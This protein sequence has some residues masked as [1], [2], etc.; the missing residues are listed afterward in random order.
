MLVTGKRM[1]PE[2]LHRAIVRNPRHLKV[3]DCDLMTFDPLG[4]EYFRVDPQLPTILGVRHLNLCT[5]RI[6]DED[7]AKLVGMMPELRSLE[8]GGNQIGGG[9][10]SAI[11]GCK[12]LQC[13]SLKMVKGI[14]VE[15][16]ETMLHECN[17]LKVL[18]MGWTCNRPKFKSE[19]SVPCSKDCNDPAGPHGMCA[20]HFAVTHAIESIARNCGQLEHLDFSGCREYVNDGHVEILVAGCTNLKT[21]DLSDSYTLTN[22]AA[23]SIMKH[24]EQLEY[25]ALSR[26][27]RIEIGLIKELAVMEGLRCIQ[28]YGCYPQIDEQL[29]EA[30]KHCSFNNNKLCQLRFDTFN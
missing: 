20:A 2:I 3:L 19:G 12:K 17:M 21:L 7:A 29:K 6:S 24:L 25:L 14:E 10:L 9:T 16:F 15:G 27:H 11:A 18:D 22:K 8:F 30:K 13:L 5:T 26:C 23:N 4:P 1:S 28:L